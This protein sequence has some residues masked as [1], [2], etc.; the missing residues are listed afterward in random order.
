MNGGGVWSN[1]GRR[2]RITINMNKKGEMGSRKSGKE[3]EGK[4]GDNERR[5]IV[6]VTVSLLPPDN[7]LGMH[8]TYKV[9]R[10]KTKTALAWVELREA[11]ANLKKMFI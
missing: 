4:I 1:R 7:H 11:D 3:E 8:V 2:K 9:M 5:G 10:T 6:K